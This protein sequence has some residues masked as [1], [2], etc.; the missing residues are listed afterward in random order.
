MDHRCNKC[1]EIIGEIGRI[2]SLPCAGQQSTRQNV[3]MPCAF[4]ESSRQIVGTDIFQILNFCAAKILNLRGNICHDGGNCKHN[5]LPCVTV[6][7]TANGVRHAEPLDRPQKWDQ[8]NSLPCVA[9]CRELFCLFR[10]V[11]SFAMSCCRCLPWTQ[12]SPCATFRYT[13]G[14]SFAVC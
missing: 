6:R 2:N 11:S 3:S 5:S 4:L 10:R 1:A 9:L 13:V 12:I 14:C 7:H 8:I